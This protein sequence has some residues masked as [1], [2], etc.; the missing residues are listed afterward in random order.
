MVFPLIAPP[1]G[2][3]AVIVL[4]ALSQDRRRTLLVCALVLATVLLDYFAMLYARR[5]MRGGSLAVMQVAA[6]VVGVL[7]VA[8][9]VRI[10]L[11]SLRGLGILDAHDPG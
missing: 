9:A 2:I 8:L 1:Y 6:A 11:M 4:L 5:I 3:V 10:I 7:Q